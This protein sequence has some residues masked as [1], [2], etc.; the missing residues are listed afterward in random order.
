MQDLSLIEGFRNFASA[1]VLG[2]LGCFVLVSLLPEG[3]MERL[4]RSALSLVF[5]SI[6][7]SSLFSLELK[8]ISLD[9]A[10]PYGGDYQLESAKLLM[11]NG[12]ILVANEVKSVLEERGFD[13]EGVEI[14]CEYDK[15]SET[16]NFIKAIIISSKLLP[17]Q[18]KNEI[19][20]KIGI[21]SEVSKYNE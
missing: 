19:F 15:K 20:D 8:G 16:I 3:A 1:V 21:D 13:Y 6:V 7:A 12:K 17:E 2:A 11:E 14:I 10:E 4:G 9:K 5:L 18:L